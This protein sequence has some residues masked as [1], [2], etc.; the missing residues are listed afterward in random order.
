[1]QAAYYTLQESRELRGLNNHLH[2][3]SHALG[4]HS[5]QLRAQGV[6]NQAP[7]CRRCEHNGWLS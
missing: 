6:H 1:M 2:D 3:L 5:Q 4:R 7:V